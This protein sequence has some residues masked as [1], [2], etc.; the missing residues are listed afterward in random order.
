VKKLSRVLGR[1]YDREISPAGINVTQLAVLRRIARLQGESLARIAEDL[2]MDRTSLYR[3]LAPMI[4][5]GWI[6]SAEGADDRS[7]T[8]RLTKKGDRVLAAA[9]QRWNGVQGRV[10]GRFGQRAYGSLLAEL[11]RLADCAAEGD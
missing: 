6:A 11:Q 4:R 10:I 5:D 8:A 1:V 7:R 9:N 3:A 2:E